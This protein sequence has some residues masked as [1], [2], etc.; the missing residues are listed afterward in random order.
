M[1]NSFYRFPQTRFWHELRDHLLALPGL[2]VTD[3]TDA[4]VVGSWLDFTFR[5]YRFTINAESGEFVFFVEKAAASRGGVRAES[6]APLERPA[7]GGKATETAVKLLSE[8]YEHPAKPA[9]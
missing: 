3:F 9:A 7:Q 4:S 8:E 5:G 1:N 2:A 6:T